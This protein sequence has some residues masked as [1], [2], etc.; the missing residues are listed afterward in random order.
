M[1]YNDDDV[2]TRIKYTIIWD[3][4]DDSVSFDFVYVP[5]NAATYV[6]PI[7]AFHI[8]LSHASFDGNKFRCTQSFRQSIIT[9]TFTSCIFGGIKDDLEFQLD[10]V[11]KYV[12]R[13]YNLLVSKE[14]K[15]AE[16][17]KIESVLERTNYAKYRALSS[18]ERDLRIREYPNY[19]RLSL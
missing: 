11:Y 14:M 5:P 15:D 3:G 6:Y 19:L 1:S 8:S 4:T 2:L 13:G 10:R 12:S 16:I 17:C 18:I 7:N 9:N